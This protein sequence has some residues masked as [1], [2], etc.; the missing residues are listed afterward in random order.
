MTPAYLERLPFI[1]TLVSNK[2]D[3]KLLPAPKSP[4]LRLT[5]AVVRPETADRGGALRGASRRARP[6]GGVDRR[7]HLRRIRRA[8]AADGALLRPRPR[9]S[10]RS[11]Q[12]AMRDVYANPTVRR[13][14]RALDAEKPAETESLEVGPAHRPSNF[15]YYVCGAAQAAFYVGRRR[16][17]GRRRSRP[18]STGSMRPSTRRSRSTAARSRS[19]SCG[20]SATTRS[21]SPPSGCSSAARAPGAIPLWSARYFR[22]WAAKAPGALRARRRL[23]RRRRSTTSI[24][25]CSARRS[26]PTR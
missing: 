18:R 14:A 25:A 13:L 1:P 21:R 15:A 24:C 2:A 8:L 17:R 4:R 23:R 10:S 20:S 3:R 6:R 26:A 19:R 11:L 5:G 22:F 7:R 12:V 9:R 16:A